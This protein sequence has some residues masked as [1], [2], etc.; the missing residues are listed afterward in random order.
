MSRSVRVAARGEIGLGEF[1]GFEL[2]GTKLVV[3]N[4]DGVLYATSGTC[5][6]N[7]GPLAQGLLEDHLVTCPWHAWEFDVRTGRAVYDPRV[8]VATYAVRVEGD[9]VFVEI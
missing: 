5:A 2:E 3:Y 4:V 6:H 7:G 8:C 9:D 1:R